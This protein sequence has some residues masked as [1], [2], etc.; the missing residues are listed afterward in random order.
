MPDVS[1]TY[2]VVLGSVSMLKVFWAK[3]ALRV[4]VV[5]LLVAEVR[6]RVTADNLRSP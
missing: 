5:E 2:S 6:E 1:V 4:K 3:S